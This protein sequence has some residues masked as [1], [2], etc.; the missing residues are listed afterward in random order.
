MQG[1]FFNWV[2]VAS[3]PANSQHKEAAALFIETLLSE[4]VQTDTLLSQGFPAVPEYVQAQLDQSGYT[5]YGS[6]TSYDSN[7]IF[8]LEENPAKLFGEIDLCIPDDP[9]LES[10]FLEEAGAYWEGQKTL[11]EAVDSICNMLQTMQAE[12]Q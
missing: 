10:R 6:K 8:T 7:T 4:P 12:R 11:D 1:W 3:I 9:V 2:T 5:G